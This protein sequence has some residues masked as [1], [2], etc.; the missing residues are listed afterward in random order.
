MKEFQF[1][2]KW[3]KFVIEENLK[4]HEMSFKVNAQK[5][6]DE[7]GA[8]SPKV[9]PGKFGDYTVFFP[10]DPGPGGATLSVGGTQTLSGQQREASMNRAK[11]AAYKFYTLVLQDGSPV[12]QGAA[13]V[14]EGRT[15]YMVFLPPL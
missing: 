13:G 8:M 6:A 15:S 5:I 4:D 7:F 11:Q 12:D 1:E 2:G 3:R 10:F 9:K 14:D